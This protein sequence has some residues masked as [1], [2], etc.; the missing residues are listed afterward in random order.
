M[1]LRTVGPSLS[2]LA[3]ALLVACGST[4]DTRHLPDAPPPPPMVDAAPHGGVTV[5]VLDPNGGTGLPSPGLPIVFFDP[6]GSVVVSELTGLDGKARADV[7]PGAS[8]VVIVNN[9]GFTLLYAVQALQPGDDIVFGQPASDNT[10]AGTFT[11]NFTTVANATSYQVYGPCGQ[12]SVTA[13]PAVLQI[14]NFCKPATTMELQVHAF[15][16]VGTSLGF[17]DKTGVAFVAGGSVAMPTTYT[18]YSAINATYTNATGISGIFLSRQAPG[19]GGFSSSSSS[20]GSPLPSTVVMPSFSGPAT[21]V[22]VMQSQINTPANATG[23][24]STGVAGNAT[25]YMLDLTANLLPWFDTP[26][27]DVATRQLARPTITTG[28]TTD[29][30]DLV[31]TFLSYNKMTSTTSHTVEWEIFGPTTAAFTLPSIPADLGDLNAAAGDTTSFVQAAMFEADSLAGW[32]AVR[33]NIF[34]SINGG[35]VLPGGTG[36]FRISQSPNLTVR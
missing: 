11:V 12:T 33:P 15:N 25:S 10:V 5:T 1:L 14:S 20:S 22:A 21:S 27:F 28:T 18:A 30:P 32:N 24:V 23:Q 31:L 9:G 7:K 4:S 26:T 3:I 13:S 19:P 6:D 2:S 35:Q 36:R 8:F 34:V 29:A 16:N 17:V